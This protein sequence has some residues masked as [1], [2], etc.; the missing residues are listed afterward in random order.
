MAVPVPYS[1]IPREVA[2]AARA[3]IEDN[4][5]PSNAG[6]RLW[7]LSGGILRCALC[8]HTTAT[9]SIK[10]HAGTFYHHYYYCRK[11]HHHGDAACTNRKNLRALDLEGRVWDL[12]SGLLKDPG[13]L[14]E[15]LNEMLEAERS[16][17]RGDP[18]AEAVAWLGRIAALDAKLSRYQDM[19]AEGHI[20]FDELG[21]KLRELE[22]E[23]ATAE[24]ELEELNVRRSRLEGLERDKETL[25]EDYASMVPEALDELAG[26]ERHQIYR[27]LRLQVHVSP[28][29]DLDVRGVLR[30]AVCTPMDTR[31]CMQGLQARVAVRSRALTR[32]AAVV[33]P[34]VPIHTCVS[35][36]TEFP[37]TVGKN[38]S[39]SGKAQVDKRDIP[40]GSMQRRR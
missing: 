26:E 39:L 20:T 1:G 36:N 14:R 28:S 5:R 2:D 15:G 23:R 7:E 16:G 31:W 32:L 9:R 22:A 29:G 38:I 35:W 18:E 6:R 33:A 10:A 8:E 4:R 34:F 21:A 19:A 37:T 30:K 13:R 25:L 24:G 12:I 17:M 27:M 11:H 40:E 3:A